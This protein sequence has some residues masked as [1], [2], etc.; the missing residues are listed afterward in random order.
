MSTRFR[1]TFVTAALAAL[2]LPIVAFAASKNSIEPHLRKF[3][4]RLAA[5]DAAGIAA[6]Y[7]KDAQLLPPQGAVIDGR[8]AIQQYWQ[9]AI[10]A[11]IKSISLDLLELHGTGDTTS[12]VGRYVVKDAAGKKIDHGKYIVIWKKVAGTW[13]LY[14]DIWNTSDAPA[15][16]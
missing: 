10:D 2:V 15:A 8:A 5:G 14:R 11:G 9:G 4:A 16:K 12:E 7:A 3:E 13:K 6:L 1:F